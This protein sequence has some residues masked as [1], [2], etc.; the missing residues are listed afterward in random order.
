MLII[1]FE[2][3][4]KLLK[5][6][7]EVR[8]AEDEE[9]DVG[10]EKNEKLDDSIVDGTDFVTEIP[11]EPIDLKLKVPPYKQVKTNH[12]SIGKSMVKEVTGYHC[13]K[14]RRFMLTEEDMLAH[15]QS[16]AHYRSFVQEIKSLRAAAEKAAKEEK[17][18]KLKAEEVEFL[19]LTIN[20][21]I[22]STKSKIQADE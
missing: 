8:S 18:A 22:I 6:E 13:E 11:E 14:C 3:L 15:L 17:E 7:A 19:V 20:N 1:T 9:K 16:N 2:F 21:L 5:G 10:L 4:E 12:L